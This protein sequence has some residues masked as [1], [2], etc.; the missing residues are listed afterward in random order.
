MIH[1]GV[2]FFAYRFE[3]HLLKENLF[4]HYVFG[5]ISI[6]DL[7]WEKKTFEQRGGYN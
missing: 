5:S 1:F 3:A 7:E 6:N 4:Y 2:N